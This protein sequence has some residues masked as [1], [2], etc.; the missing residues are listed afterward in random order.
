MRPTRMTTVPSA[1]LFCAVSAV[2][3]LTAAALTAPASAMGRSEDP[4][5]AQP[6]PVGTD[7]DPAI[8]RSDDNLRQLLS[9][10]DATLPPPAGVQDPEMAP[11]KTQ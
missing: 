7:A 11:D 2:F 6:V 10:P 8:R 5:D 4:R 3:V 1:T 9:R